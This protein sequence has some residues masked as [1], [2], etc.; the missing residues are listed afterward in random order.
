MAN[1]RSLTRSMQ[2]T[3]SYKL[4]TGQDLYQQPTYGALQTAL[5]KVWKE[6][7]LK[8][9][10]TGE[11]LVTMHFVHTYTEIKKQSIIWLPGESTADLT[12][13]HIVDAV[14]RFDSLAVRGAQ[15]TLYVISIEGT[16]G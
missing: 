3:V 14:G 12:A 11:E 8:K 7:V 5:A 16:G 6:Q 9:T 1:P 13:G 10:A 2:A 15:W 4:A